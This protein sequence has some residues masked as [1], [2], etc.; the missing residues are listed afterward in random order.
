[1]AH[2]FEELATGE[3]DGLYQGALF[4]TAGDER[5]AESLLVEALGRSFRA[6]SASDSLEDIRR[7]LEGKLVATY[8]ARNIGRARGTEPAPWPG[9]RVDPRVF[10][11][12]DAQGL[13]AAAAA[14]PWAARAALWLV[15]LRRWPYDDAS[16]AMGVERQDLKDLLRHRHTLMGAILGG[17][18]GRPGTRWAAG[19]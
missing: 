5:R 9:D 19:R 3:L 18:G 11:Q 4:L 15:L 14:V 7:W 13:H 10:D 6:F 1:M 8:I 12:L 16:L 2:T 17:K